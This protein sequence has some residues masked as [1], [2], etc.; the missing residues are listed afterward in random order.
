MERFPYMVFLYDGLLEIYIDH[1]TLL[2]AKQLL[3]I[4]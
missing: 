2:N 3:V 4:E 1:R